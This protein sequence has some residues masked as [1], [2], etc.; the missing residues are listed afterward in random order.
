L[1]LP[2]LRN[3][4]EAFFKLEDHPGVVA[5]IKRVEALPGWIKRV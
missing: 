1:P 3:S 5:W 4:D 2:A